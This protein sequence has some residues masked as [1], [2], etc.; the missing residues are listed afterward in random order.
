[1]ATKADDVLT[2]GFLVVDD[3]YVNRAL[4]QKMLNQLKPDMG[5][6]TANDGQEAIDLAGKHKYRMIFMDLQ[7][8]R[9]D[10]WQAIAH[11]QKGGINSQTPI[12]ITSANTVKE[13]DGNFGRCEVLTKPIKAADLK[14]IVDRY[15]V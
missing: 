11:I 6:H 4:L 2:I 1:M 3:S 15:I 7:M 12:V 13:D 5:L 9:V 10:G 14:S 8:P